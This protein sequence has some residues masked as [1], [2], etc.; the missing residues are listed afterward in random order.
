[1]FRWMIE[2]Y[3]VSFFAQKLGTAV[4]VSPQRLDKQFEKIR[5]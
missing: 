3:R 2:E 5:Q 1:M 4:K